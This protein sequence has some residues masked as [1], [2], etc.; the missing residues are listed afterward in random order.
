MYGHK[1]LPETAVRFMV[2]FER[3]RKIKREKQKEKEGE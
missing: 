2:G 1:R 3:K